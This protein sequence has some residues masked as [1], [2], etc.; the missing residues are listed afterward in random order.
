ME[1]DKTY[2]T[3][4]FKILL[5]QVKRFTWIV[6]NGNKLDLFSISVSYKQNTHF[7]FT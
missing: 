3:F 6:K 5:I 2:S 7:L 1:E 4:T